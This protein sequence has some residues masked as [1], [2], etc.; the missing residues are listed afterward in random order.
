MNSVMRGLGVAFLYVLA[1]PMYLV[2]ALIKVIKSVP[3]MR[4][5]RSG[6]VICPHCR[7]ENDLDVKATCPKCRRTEF[8]NRLRC[9]G[10]L[11]E[12]SSFDCDSCGTTI[13]L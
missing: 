9:R 1:A 4:A 8:G 3:A 13:D 2:I 12:A 10:C 6:V 11:N 7:A 5:I